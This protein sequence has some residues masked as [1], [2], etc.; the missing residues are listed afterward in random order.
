MGFGEKIMKKIA[1]VGLW[2]LG[3]VTAACLANAG[4]E[5]VAYDPDAGNIENLQKGI[6]IIFE[7]GLQEILQR[8]ISEK[9]FL[10]TSNLDDLAA[11]SLVW[12]NYDTPVDDADIADIEYVKNQIKEII[13][14]LEINTTILIS[15][16]L[17]V[18]T[19]DELQRFVT[20]NYPAKNIS[21]AYSPENLRLGKAIEVFHN[22]ERV[23]VGVS[24]SVDRQK[25]AEVFAPF[26]ENLIWMKVESAEMVKHALNAFLA[27]SVVFINEIASLCEQTRANV[28]EVE[29]GLKSDSRIGYKAYLRAGEAIAG[30]TLA[31]DVNFLNQK[32]MQ[33]STPTPLLS[34]ILESNQR[35]KQWQLHKIKVVLKNLAAKKVAILGLAYKANTDTLRRSATLETCFQLNSEGCKVSAYDPIISSLPADVGE[36]VTLQSSLDDALD[37]ADALII[38]NNYPEFS[39]LNAEKLVQLMKTPHVID[40]SGFL[41]TRIADN[42]TVS[43]YTVGS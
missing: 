20:N 7:P 9:K 6:P 21:F 36:Y 27:T 23:I 18:G 35:H 12:V 1:V 41:A 37:N 30:G 2:H 29:Q 24:N 42:S 3:T 5:V 4:F 26:S 32:S 16:Q 8:G 14:H 33:A 38:T 28:K 17:P 22:P 15:S 13:P 40:A 10:P 39:S 43:Y 34:S 19:T 31:R 11:A 25:I